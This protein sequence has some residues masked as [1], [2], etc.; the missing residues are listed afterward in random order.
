MIE[1]RY[2]FFNNRVKK[3]VFRKKKA[4]AK[5]FLIMKAIAVCCVRDVIVHTFICASVE[6]WKHVESLDHGKHRERS[7]RNSYVPFTSSN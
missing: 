2:I 7:Y 3:G 5:F 4:L 6:V 1:T